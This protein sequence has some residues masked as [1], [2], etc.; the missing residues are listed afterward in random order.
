MTWTKINSVVAD[1]EASNTREDHKEIKKTKTTPTID[2]IDLTPIKDDGSRDK[3]I[4]SDGE[5]DIVQDLNFSD[6]D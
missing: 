3:N 4:S 2:L 1:T 6:S 5:S